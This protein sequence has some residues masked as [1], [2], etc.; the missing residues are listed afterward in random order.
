V[1]RIGGV[2]RVD[3][4]TQAGQALSNVCRDCEEQ[5]GRSDVLRTALVG[6]KSS[7]SALCGGHLFSRKKLGVG[8]G[9][10]SF[11]AQESNAANARRRCSVILKAAAVIVVA[12]F[13]CSA[14]ELNAQTVWLARDGGA[15]QHRFCA[16]SGIQDGAGQNR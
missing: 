15:L 1:G 16:G 14:R 11:T 7:L 13:V 10:P 3:Q 5:R 2:F 4:R 12:L 6:R 9:G 8:R